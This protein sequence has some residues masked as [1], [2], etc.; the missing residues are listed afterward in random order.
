MFIFPT[1]LAD[2]KDQIQNLESVVPLWTELY[3]A[4]DPS[5]LLLEFF[6]YKTCWNMLFLKRPLVATEKFKPSRIFSDKFISKGFSQRYYKSTFFCNSFKYNKYLGFFHQLDFFL[7]VSRFMLFSTQVI[8]DYSKNVIWING[9]IGVIFIFGLGFLTHRR[10]PQWYI[11][12][13]GLKHPSRAVIHFLLNEK[14]VKGLA[15]APKPF[16]YYIFFV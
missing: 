1:L 7:E 12:T 11:P 15:K 14:S 13:R 8:F 16:F 9:F 3:I 10:V 2:F 5:I 4:Q 6:S